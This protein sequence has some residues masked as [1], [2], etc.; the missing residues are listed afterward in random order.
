M[1]LS[2]SHTRVTEVPISNFIKICQRTESTDIEF[3]QA[4]E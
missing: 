4:V 2:Y 1:K 3:I